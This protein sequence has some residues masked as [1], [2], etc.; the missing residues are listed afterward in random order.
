[1]NLIRDAWITAI[2]AKSGRCV[3][4]PWQI[5]ELE[6][7]VMD[8][9]APRPDFQGAMHQFLIGLL[10]TG[11]SPDDLDEWLEYWDKPPDA[12]VLKERLELLVAAFEFDNPGGAA[13]MQDF[14]LPDGE[15]KGVAALLIEAPGGKT[16]RDNLDHFVKRD[17]VRHV[18]K[19]CAAMALFT[20][21]TNAPSGG[22]GHRVG[23]RG[24]GPLTTLVLPPDEATLWRKLWLNVLDREDIP[25]YRQEEEQKIFPW[26]VETRTSEK[27][28]TETTPKD[29]HLLQMYWGMPRRIRIDFPDEPLLGACDLCDAHNVELVEEYRTRNYGVNYTG[30][31]IHPLTPYWFDPD[32]EKFPNSR[33]GQ[34]GGLGYRDWLVLTFADEENG[35]TSAKIVRRYTEQRAGELKLQRIARLWCFG[36]A[37]DKMKAKC[38]YDNTFP[39]FN[40]DQ[41]QRKRLVQWSGEFITTAN[42]VSGYLK[43]HIKAAWFRRPEDAKGDMNVV[44]QDFW[45]RTEQVF[46]DLLQQLAEIA[47][48]QDTPPPELYSR[49]EKNMLSVPLDIF[50]TWVLEAQVEDMDMLGVIRERDGLKRQIGGC[51]S[52]KTI[53]AKALPEEKEETD[54]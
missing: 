52:M 11:F 17:T 30:E 13:F 8:L 39:L 49:W 12:A 23:L 6:D 35:H 40:L 2:R 15:R 26:L 53:K 24:G 33:K 22:V 21:Q 4:A 25:E 27:N 10:Q 34:E 41:A 9:A 48:Q 16:I 42:D 7:P 51:K 36:F 29:T 54:G 18:C 5:A 32:K 46:F 31:W 19:P 47:V 44:T 1:M 45:Q 43:K 3:I 20:L 50:D 28:G 14:A 37:M 38:W